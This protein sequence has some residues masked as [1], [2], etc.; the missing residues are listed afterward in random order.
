MFRKEEYMHLIIDSK[1]KYKIFF[2]PIRQEILDLIRSE[3][4]ALTIDEVARKIEMTNSKTH[5]HMKRLED[6]GAIKSSFET[7]V[8]GIVSKHYI[9]A[10]MDV[11]IKMNVKEHLTKNLIVT[12][13]MKFQKEIFNENCISLEQYSKETFD[14]I[15]ADEEV[16]GVHFHDQDVYLTFEQRKQLKELVN[17]FMVENA[18]MK[19]DESKYTKTHIFCQIYD[20]EIINNEEKGE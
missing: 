18:C 16:F 1:K 2:D 12:E 13:Q 17:D 3:Y 20:K 8:N 7:V 9:L 6:L 5:Y 15:E 4:Q 11:D 19:L 10:F 14:R